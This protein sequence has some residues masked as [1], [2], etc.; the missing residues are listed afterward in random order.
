MEQ[1]KLLE[2]A[3]DGVSGKAMDFLQQSKKTT[4]PNKYKT[5]MQLHDQCVEDC[6]EINRMI[7]ELG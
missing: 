6:K 5:F 2:Y 1:R 4:N 3:R 7:K